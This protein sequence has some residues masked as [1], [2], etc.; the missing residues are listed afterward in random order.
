MA[1]PVPLPSLVDE[2]DG[3]EYSRFSTQLIPVA[4]DCL[5]SEAQ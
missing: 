4:Y 3:H 1:R 5:Y 2:A